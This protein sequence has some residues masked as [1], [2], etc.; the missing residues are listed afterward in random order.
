[1]SCGC[2]SSYDGTS[3]LSKRR[4]SDNLTGGMGDASSTIGK[5][6]SQSLEKEFDDFAYEEVP[7]FVPNLNF[8]DLDDMDE[9]FDN[10]LTKKMRTKRKA[11][12]QKKQ[13]A[14]NNPINEGETQADNNPINEGGIDVVGAD[15]NPPMNVSAK[16]QEGFLAKNQTM[17]LIAGGVVLLVGGYFLFG[18][19]LGIRG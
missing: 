16:Q 14:D 2:T 12:K 13:Q 11:K 4:L 18:K 19:K 17:L 6:E 1:M 7:A 3:D 9:N 15:V 5:L 8:A 10:F